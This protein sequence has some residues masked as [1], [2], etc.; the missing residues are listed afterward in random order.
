MSQI[1]DVKYEKYNYVVVGL[2]QQE[3]PC[4]RLS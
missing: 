2:S 1:E 3:G 4:E